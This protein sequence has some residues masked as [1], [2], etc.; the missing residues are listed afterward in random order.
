MAKNIIIVVFSLCFLLALYLFATKDSSPLINNIE[1]TTENPKAAFENFRFSRYDKV[2][3][4][5]DLSAKAGWFRDPHFLELMGDV[6]MY[7]YGDGE[8][9]FS[10]A[11]TVVVQYDADNLNEIIEGAPVEHARFHEFVELK[12][13]NQNQSY[14][15]KTDFAEYIAVDRV[16]K[17]NRPVEVFGKDHHLRG[18][19]G[20]VYAM[21]RKELQIEGLVH[22]VVELKNDET[23]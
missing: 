7:Q 4:V 23:K 9:R 22:G 8:K 12:S 10:G 11:E 2:S 21:D 17:S 20:F 14:T 5:Y 16:F 18:S 19:E 6:K 3:M 1:N 13:Q 15:L